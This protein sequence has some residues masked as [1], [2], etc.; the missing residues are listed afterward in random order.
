MGYW[1]GF[2]AHA[3]RVAAEVREELGLEPLDP[4]DPFALAEHL[5]IPAAPL[6]S[7]RTTIPDAVHYLASVDTGAFSAVT[8]FDGPRRRIVYNDAHSR[9]RQ[10][11]DIAH[12]CAHGLL[13][14]PPRLAFDSA[15]CRDWNADEEDEANWLSAA[16]L[17]TEQAAL[18]IV[19]REMDVN[20]A[21]HYYGVS[22]QLLRWRINATGAVKRVGRGRAASRR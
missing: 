3:N 19:R 5:A 15:G 13:L 21:A 8:L 4:L 2:K 1:H 9:G 12:E 7:L 14:H 11:S 6:S 18:H 20:Q 17:I 10:H 16:L 22:R